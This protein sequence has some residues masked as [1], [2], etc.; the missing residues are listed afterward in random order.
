MPSPASGAISRESDLTWITCK[1]AWARLVSIK[2]VCKATSPEAGLL[3]GRRN[4]RT[5]MN[6]ASLF[7]LF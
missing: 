1:C 7:Y 6:D 2:A 4:L 3:R 5:A